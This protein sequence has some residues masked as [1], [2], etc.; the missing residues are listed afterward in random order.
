MTALL[1]ILLAAAILLLL[2]LI[3]LYNRLVRSRILVSEGFSGIDVQLKRRHN[4]VPNLVRTVKGYAQFERSVL[5]EVTR[6]RTNS[7]MRTRSPPR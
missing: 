5:E 4:L 7:G 6:L 1:I 3:L 2:A